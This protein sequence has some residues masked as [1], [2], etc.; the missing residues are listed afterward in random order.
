MVLTG[1]G[2]RPVTYRVTR[3]QP[4][5]PPVTDDDLTFYYCHLG[6]CLLTQTHSTFPTESKIPEVWGRVPFPSPFTLSDPATHQGGLN[7]VG[8]A[9]PKP[10]VHGKVG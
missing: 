10:S 5:L 3:L 8:V 2:P 7:V 4:R 6:S 1:A 9:I